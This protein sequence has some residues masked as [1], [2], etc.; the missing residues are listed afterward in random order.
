M[1]EEAGVRILLHTV[2]ADVIKDGERVSGVI[3][4]GK[5]GREAILAH[6]VID[7]TG[8]ADAAALAGTGVVKNTIQL[9]QGCRLHD[10]CG[11]ASAG[12]IL[13]EKTLSIS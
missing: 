6:T 9:R 5:S 12:G 1:L 13:P 10:K 2:I 7:S 4:E 3:I 11:Y 8:D